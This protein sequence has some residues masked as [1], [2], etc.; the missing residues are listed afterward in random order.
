MESEKT[1]A[2]FVQ[3][4]REQYG[5][6]V[7]QALALTEQGECNAV[8]YEST[9]ASLYVLTDQFLSNSDYSLT[10]VSG[11][12]GNEAPANDQGE[13]TTGTDGTGANETG[14]GVTETDRTGIAGIT[15]AGDI[16][17][18]EDGFVIDHYD[19]AAGIEECISPAIIAQTNAADVFMLNNEF[20]ISER[21]EPL[22]GK[23]YTFRAMPSRISIL[24]AL[25]TDVASL[26]NNHVYDYGE[27]AM[28]DTARYLKEA[29]IVTVGGGDNKTEAEKVIYLNVNGIKI[30]IVSASRAEKL[31]YTPQATEESAGIFL[32]Y[33]PER[34]LEVTRDA[35]KR[36][37]YLVAYI[38]WGTEDS[39][40]F[41]EYQHVL[42]KQIFDAG[43][44][45]IIGGHPHVLQGIEYIDGKPVVYSLGDFW[46]NDET[47]YTA[48]IH[49]DVNVK[50]LSQM[51][52]VP[53]LQSHYTTTLIEEESERAAF[54][55]YVRELSVSC[56]IGENGVIQGQ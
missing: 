10:V 16:C 54:M 46:F 43:A 37:D 3:W 8:C 45:I 55:Q 47:K 49:I 2:D 20:S 38:H 39:R 15:F 9:G 12:K 35:A 34:L 1:T 26:A 31:R 52:I 42:A 11:E 19:M 33:D 50:G 36:C 25:G 13:G 21:G 32:M 18:E 28:R 22:A 48:L 6:G 27:E 7:I 40:Y 29:G 56:E 23:Y 4:L 17:L 41:E 51:V 24:Q 53:C 5:T 44:D 30:G 14:I